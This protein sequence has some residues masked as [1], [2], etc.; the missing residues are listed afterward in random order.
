MPF[1]HINFDQNGPPYH[2]ASC[3]L[4][5]SCKQWEKVTLHILKTGCYSP[6]DDKTAS[7]SKTL[8]LLREIEET[9]NAVLNLKQDAV[10]DW[11]RLFGRRSNRRGEI[12][13]IKDV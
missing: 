5:C 12:F 3:C 2:L 13:C 11:E 7:L 9:G 6:V 4:P 10:P 1:Y 8:Y